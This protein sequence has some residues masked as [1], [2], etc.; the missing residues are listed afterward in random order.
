[1]VEPEYIERA[2]AD[3]FE[4]FSPETLPGPYQDAYLSEDTEG[5]RLG[6]LRMYG[7]IHSLSRT[8]LETYNQIADSAER[9]HYLE[10]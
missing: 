8:Q 9:S 10:M 4:P 3:L 2:V 1:M 6:R 5:G 7:E